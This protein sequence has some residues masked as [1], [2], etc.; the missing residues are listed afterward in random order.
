MST[1]ILYTTVFLMG[2]SCAGSFCAYSAQADTDGLNTYMSQH[3]EDKSFQDAKAHMTPEEFHQWVQE[4]YNQD[5]K[6]RTEKESPSTQMS[7]DYD[8]LSLD[9][10]GLNL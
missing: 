3:M 9:P 4:Q 6:D 7:T 2:F 8:D 1:N 5:K 10:F